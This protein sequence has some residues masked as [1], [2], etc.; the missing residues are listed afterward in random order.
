MFLFPEVA[1]LN[2]LEELR[3]VALSI[4]PLVWARRQIAT[5]VHRE[6]RKA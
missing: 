4:G 3:H 1:V 2:A 6:D 5:A